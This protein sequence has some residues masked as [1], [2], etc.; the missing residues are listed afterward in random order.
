MTPPL[1]T[2]VV[3]AKR[4]VP[5]R[6]KTRLIG[7]AGAAAAVTAEQAADLAAAALRDTLDV[8]SAVPA[9][10]RVLLFDGDPTG[11]LPAD[12]NLVEQVGGELDERLSAGLESLPDGPALLVGMDTPQLLADH[13]TFDPAAWDSCL[14]LA[15]DGGYWAIGLAEPRRAREV[16]A[17][18]PM[19]VSDTGS[20]QL[21]RLHDAGLSVQALTELVDVDTGEDAAAVAAA[22]PWTRFARTWNAIAGDHS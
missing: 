8:I 10:R 9:Q 14:G 17:G 1:G 20:H 18:V 12:W 21:R 13:L 2:L 4:P 22:A 6:V 5:G 19:S 16:I 7:A 11:W 15:S 3:I